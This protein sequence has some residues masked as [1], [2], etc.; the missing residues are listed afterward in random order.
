MAKNL[1]LNMIWKTEETN[2]QIGKK[3]KPRENEEEEIQDE[4]L[5]EGGVF[6]CVKEWRDVQKR[7][8]YETPCQ[9]A[10]RPYW[11][12]ECICC[13]IYEWTDS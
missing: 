3:N 9:R 12:D 4:I 11:Q 2:V 8:E 10:E 13:R 6:L 7:R 1:K 5:R